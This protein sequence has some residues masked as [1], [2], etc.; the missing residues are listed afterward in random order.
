MALLFV[1]LL[2][3]LLSISSSA[4]GA[5]ASALASR[6]GLQ[7]GGQPTCPAQCQVGPRG[8][9]DG[10]DFAFEGSSDSIP[11]F[12]IV[13]PN[14]TA[15]DF[16]ISPPVVVKEGSGVTISSTGIATFFCT[17]ALTGPC[18][19]GNQFYITSEGNSSLVF[20]RSFS[21]QAVAFF[22][23]RWV[24]LPILTAQIP[25]GGTVLNINPGDNNPTYPEARRHPSNSSSP[26]SI[27]PTSSNTHP[28]PTHPSSP[29]S[30]PSSPHQPLFLPSTWCPRNPPLKRGEGAGKLLFIDAHVAGAAGDMLV[31]SLLDLGVPSTVV[32]GAV[33]AMGLSHVTCR[34]EATQ[35]SAI[36][37]PL[38]SVDDGANQPYRDYAA[39]RHLLANSSLPRGARDIASRAFRLLAEAEACVH[40]M[41]VDDVHFH[42][43]G[44]VD[45]IVD[46]VAAAAAIDYLAPSHIAASPLPMA[47]GIIS[48]AAHGPLPSPAPATLEIL[49]RANIPTPLGANI[50]TF[51]AGCKGELVTPTGAALL[52][53]I[54]HTWTPWPDCRPCRASYG[55]GTKVRQDRPNLLR[56]V[57]ADPM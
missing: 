48:G 18:D 2:P 57:L 10:C 36:T 27:P 45:S 22:Q 19:A 34:V 52:A 38:F 42:E 8:P 37:A 3:L 56:L 28:S 31:A 54:T 23:N 53:A 32:E 40:G 46:M 4:N 47:R 11:T 35:R 39:I 44:A 16:A 51:A 30:H 29:H 20:V 25:Q 1:F 14:A 6:R 12:N 33:E 41:A 5:Q 55:A 17:T 13:P 26:S 24:R 49:C 15:G 21:Q 7:Q 43:V 50:P 9:L